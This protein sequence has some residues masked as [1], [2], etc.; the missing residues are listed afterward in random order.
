MYI[1][2]VLLST[3]PF[4]FISD[5]QE[6]QDTGGFLHRLHFAVSDPHRYMNHQIYDAC[7]EIEGVSGTEPKDPDA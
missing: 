4:F 3:A 7:V 6:R 1:R 2:N 5:F